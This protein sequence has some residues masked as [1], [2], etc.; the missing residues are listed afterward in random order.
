MKYK[1][2]IVS[3]V[4]AHIISISLGFISSILIARGLGATNQGQF[5][6]YVLIFGIIATY[7]HFGF[8]TSI[9][10]FLKKTKFG[11]DKVI[12][13]NISV[14]CIL[15]AIYFACL[16]FLRNLIFESDSISLLIIWTIYFVSLLVSTMLMNIYM[17][18]ENVYVYNRYLNA[19]AILK[20]LLVLALFLINSVTVMYVSIVYSLLELIKL[21]LLISGLKFKYKFEIDKRIVL[22]ELKYGIPLYLSGLFLYLNYRADQVMIKY[23]IDNTALGIYALSVTL[24]ELAKMVPDSVVSAFTGKLYNCSENVKKRVVTLTIKLSFYM[25]AVISIIGICCKPLI[26]VLYGEEYIM[27]GLSMIILLIGIPFLS[28]GKVSAVYFYTHGKTKMHMNISIIVLIINLVL[29]VF[30]IPKYGIYGAAF[31]STFS[32]IVYGLI[33]L[34]I[35]GKSNFSIKELVIINKSDINLLKDKI[36]SVK[37]KLKKV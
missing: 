34:I 24:A 19:M 29:N 9:S 14:I 3:N 37:R 16:I 12:N 4:I 6:F 8:T 23:Y 1:K 10:Y 30:L 7:G 20:T 33:Y 28:I 13:T 11:E 26:G 18:N 36:S 15:S 31:T 22:E 35:L 27:A 17:A 25:T 32:Y 2:N 5:S 21:L